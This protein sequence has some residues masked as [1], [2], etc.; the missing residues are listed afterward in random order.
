MSAKPTHVPYLNVLEEDTVAATLLNVYAL[1]PP[2][3]PVIPKTVWP[4]TSLS[5]V[6]PISLARDSYVMYLSDTPVIPP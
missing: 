6:K 4:D 2:P 5:A 3:V 1:Y